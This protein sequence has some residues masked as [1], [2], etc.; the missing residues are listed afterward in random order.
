MRGRYVVCVP[1]TVASDQ[2]A[3]ALPLLAEFERRQ[4]AGVQTLT[5]SSRQ[6]VFAAVPLTLVLLVA[7]SLLAWFRTGSWAQVWAAAP[8][9]LVVVLMLQ[10]IRNRWRRPSEDE[11]RCQNCGYILRHLTVPLPGVR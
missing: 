11:P 3:A 10:R 4:T 6:D 9:M 7:L 2:V 1:V 8:L 5:T